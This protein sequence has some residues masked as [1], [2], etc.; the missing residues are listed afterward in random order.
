MGQR[1]GEANAA[2]AAEEKRLQD[3]ENYRI[4]E[5]RRLGRGSDMPAKPV[6]SSNGFDRRY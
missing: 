1:L 5:A 4:L 2:K 3:E 6:F